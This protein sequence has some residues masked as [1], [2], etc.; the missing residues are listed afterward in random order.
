M[1][2]MACTL[3]LMALIVI[4][5][6]PVQAQQE[7]V[8]VAIMTFTEGQLYDYWWDWRLPEGIT[9][10]VTDELV[11]KNRLKV[12]ERTRIDEILSEQ[13][14][15]ADD[16]LQVET[17]S[18]IGKLLGARLMVMGT[19]TTFELKQTGRVGVG[20]LSVSGTQAKVVLTGRIVDTETGEILGSLKGEG[21]KT[22]AS[23]SV[24][25]FKGI[26]FDSEQFQNSTLG[27]ATTA[28]VEQFVDNLVTVAE[29]A[30]LK[31]AKAEAAV[32]SSGS[33]LV[34]LP[35]NQIVINLGSNQGMTLNTKMDI[36]HLTSIPGMKEPIR[37][38]V[39]TARIISVDPDAS[40]AIIESKTQDIQQGDVVAIQ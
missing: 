6:L 22:G 2:K 36:F 29:K 26:S 11:K 4:V 15:G 32:A 5:A 37:I 10:L 18:K 16:F 13:R 1:R 34:V 12:V 23:L 19:I 40:V 30:N 38:P 8:A 33:V 7:K 39:G 9:N 3:I 28:A 27:Q 14:L 35:G 25:Y 31:V 17:A 21:S 20:F 24:S